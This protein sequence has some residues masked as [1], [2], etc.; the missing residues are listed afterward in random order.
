MFTVS[1]LSPDRSIQDE[2]WYPLALGALLTI[3]SQWTPNTKLAYQAGMRSWHD[4]AR[5]YGEPSSMPPR[6]AAVLAWLHWMAGEG[7]A[8]STIYLRLNGLAWADRWC[9][10]VPG[11]EP[12]S[13]LHHPQIKAWKRGFSKQSPLRVRD[14]M[15]PTQDELKAIVSACLKARPRKGPYRTPLIASRDRALILLGYYGAM[16]KSEIVALRVCDIEQTH[17]GIEINFRRSKTDQTGTGETRAL[18]AQD[19]LLMCPVHAWQTW[20]GHYQPESSKLP[21]FVGISNGGRRLTGKALGY[22]AISKI[23]LHRCRDASVRH[24]SPHQ[25]RA[26]FATHAAERNDEG[27]IAFHGRWKSRSTMDRYVKRGR[28]WT[29]EKNPTVGLTR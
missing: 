1:E 20:L 21:A 23:M 5:D 7:Y 27:E 15:P 22:Q 2:A 8:R 9:R 28:T 18:F 19:E 14:P 11:D 24:I 25:L 10:S 3:S 12:Y 16:R 6:P 13:L 4:W 29:R 26:A 17:R